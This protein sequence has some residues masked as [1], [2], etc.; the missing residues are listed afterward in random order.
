MNTRV[1]RSGLVVG[2]ELSL[3]AV[4]LATVLAGCASPRPAGSGSNT[5]SSGTQVPPGVTNSTAATTPFESA[6]D[7]VTRSVVNVAIS[8]AVPS[9]S[10]S[11]QVQ[12]GNG[13]GIIIRPDGYILTNNHVVA[14]STSILVG[15]GMN[16]IPAKII[17][18][19][20]STDLAVIKIA[21]TGL[22]AA[23]PGDPQALQRGQWVIAVGSPFG[24]ER[25]V[26]AGIVSAL[27][28]STV[29]QTG[30]TSAAYTNL[31]QTDAA[32]NPGNSGGA[33][34]TLDGKVVG[35][36]SLDESP[37]GASA[38]VGFAIPID[39][40][41]SIAD[42][43]IKT[44]HAVHPYIG[45]AVI[46]LDAHVA[47]VLGIK[48]ATQG[49]LVQSV[50]KSGPAAKAGIKKGDVISAIGGLPVTDSATMF[51]ALR[52]QKIGATVPVEIVRN[53]KKST[54]MLTIG[55]GATG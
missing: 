30:A 29:D 17:G 39:F 43:L 8:E 38:G 7:L 34:A 21:R 48:G 35:V 28:R 14:G 10:G 9:P 52:A 54:V 50:T 36:S 18:Q 42:Q 15:L 51:A 33:L 12:T 44:G 49:A 31:I 20:P 26:T 41:L 4:V 11:Q 19:D 2:L 47:S 1:H 22:I 13:S 25:T 3:T 6:A 32:I 5:P 37:S 45:V 27:N 53:G 16:Q 55:S 40:A 46:D 23:V 24:L